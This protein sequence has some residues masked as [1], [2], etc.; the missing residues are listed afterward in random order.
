MPIPLASVLG[1]LFPGAAARITDYALGKPFQLWG[2]SIDA[3]QAPRTRLQ[4]YRPNRSDPNVF[5]SPDALLQAW[6]QGLISDSGVAWA[7]ASQ[8][9]APPAE[10]DINSPPL[11][12][13]NYG[14]DQPNETF[15]Y[16]SQLWSAVSKS[17]MS[18]PAPGD[19]AD[20]LW[21]GRIEMPQYR[22]LGRNLY[23]A[24]DMFLQ[25]AAGHYQQPGLN[26]LWQLWRMGRIS[27]EDYALWTRRLGWTNR[28]ALA[29][30]QQVTVLPTVTEMLLAHYRGGLSMIELEQRMQAAGYTSARERNTVLLAN[31][32]LPSP[33]DL[34]RFAVRE[35]W[36]EDA[37][38]RF[39]YDLEFPEPFRR[40]MQWFGL[41]WG[42]EMQGAGGQRFPSVPWPLAYWVAHW[43]VMSPQQGYRAVHLLRPDRIHRYQQIAPG[44]T[45]FTTADLSTLL[46]VSDYPPP[47]RNWL[48][49]IAFQP[50]RL[51]DI[52][53]S[54]VN[55]IR[56]RQWAVDQLL[57]RG[58]VREDA[59]TVADLWQ[60]TDT[61]AVRQAANAEQKAI[62]RQIITELRAAY[63][64]GGLSAQTVSSRLAGMGWSSPQI[65]RLLA[66]EDARSARQRLEMFLRQ[67]RRSYLSGALSDQEAVASL[68]AAK[69]S[70]PAIQ[71]YIRLWQSE[72]G[73]ERR[74]LSTAQIVQAVA[75]G[76]LAPQ[77]AAI[78]LARLGWTE[79]DSALLLQEAATKL[80][81]A[82]AQAARQA[83]N[84]AARQAANLQ[85]AQSQAKQ[86][87]LAAQRQLRQ[88]YPLGTLKHQFCL[89]IRKGPTI[90][91]LLVS[92]GY[93]PDSIAALLKQ[94]TIDCESNPPAAD[95]VAVAGT[96]YARRQTPLSTIKQWWQNGVVTDQWARAR[97]AAIGIEPGAIPATIQLWQ[98]TLGKK[99]GP[100]TQANPQTQPTL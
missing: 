66:L 7:L 87:A 93:T 24:H 90:S 43:Q 49:A 20:L 97:L 36:D 96:A 45:P 18:R 100:A 6:R 65:Q 71:H 27:D 22:L 40:W 72:L 31:R 9:I 81:R 61:I 98:S 41:D 95:K 63:R 62:T 23:A 68:Q 55:G 48:Q 74:S 56:D 76:M 80:T 34:V 67:L 78:R 53:S 64:M 38:R 30:S 3:T 19:L 26:D 51:T 84:T 86:A 44:V 82:Q 50:L 54:L 11:D 58:Y 92:Q 75:S 77:V 5:P 21:R 32:P 15:N 13:W 88:I 89:G 46:K 4:A 33:A 17:G 39:G 42:Q 85:A 10:V 91:A 28:D 16:F 35:V 83:A 29:L 73:I 12:V 14:A 8:G 79:P 70:A 60:S 2:R 47:V 94:W 1:T 99:S 69:I 57:D 37:R 52:R 59:E 25:A